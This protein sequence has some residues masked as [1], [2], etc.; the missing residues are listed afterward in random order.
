VNDFVRA[1]PEYRSRMDTQTVALFDWLK[2]K[3][4]N[5]SAEGLLHY[6][7]PSKAMTLTESVVSGLGTL[8][9]NGLLILF[10]VGLILIEASS[11]PLKLLAAVR[12]PVKTRAAYQR[13]GKTAQR[14][15]L[16]KTLTSAAEGLAIWLCLVIIGVDY[17]ALWGLLAFLFNFVPYLGGILA[18]V[19]PVLL[20]LLQLGVGPAVWTIVA[21]VFV[22]TITAILE[23][24]LVAGGGAGLS[25][26]VVFLS[27]AFWGWV[28]GPV[29]AVLSVP[30]TIILKSALESHEDSRWVAMMLGQNPFISVGASGPQD[31]PTPALDAVTKPGK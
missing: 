3:N 9:G 11:F 24:L 1:L 12:N 5:V 4:I 29:G 10:T 15:L 26:L 31:H 16:I 19:P 20:A 30:L 28:L 23:P 14:Y 22:N 25:A 6:F 27:L 8:L 21:C 13:F 18:T 7:A 2:S 17:P